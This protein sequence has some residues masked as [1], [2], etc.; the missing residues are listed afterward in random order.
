V[1]GN[2]SIR[3]F[4]TAIIVTVGDE[5]YYGSYTESSGTIAF[6]VP[7]PDEFIF[8]SGVQYELVRSIDGIKIN[9]ILF[10]KN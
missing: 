3:F 1:D 4:P 7:F 2:V 6:D 5:S 10:T 9:G 8:I